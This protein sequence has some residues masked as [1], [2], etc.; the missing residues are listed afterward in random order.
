[1]AN[2]VYNYKDSIPKNG[3]FRKIDLKKC[4]ITR[5]T[6]PHR[7]LTLINAKRKGIQPFPEREVFKTVRTSK[8][9]LLVNPT[10]VYRYILYI[11]DCWCYFP[12]ASYPWN[13]ILYQD[14]LPSWPAHSSTPLLS[15][16]KMPWGQWETRRQKV[17]GITAGS[18]KGVG[19][20]HRHRQQNTTRNLPNN[21]SL[22]WKQ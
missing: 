9:I 17:S 15:T 14:S 20:Q 12:H 21:N 7:S 22:E 5:I 1:M 19:P 13:C 2:K 11:S 16:L 18:R 4:R 8:R 6:L 10:N 3:I